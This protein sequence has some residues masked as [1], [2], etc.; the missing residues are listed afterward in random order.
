MLLQLL[1]VRFEH[2]PTDQSLGLVVCPTKFGLEV[3]KMKI[4][5]KE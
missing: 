2:D 4:I 5:I 1:E 3:R